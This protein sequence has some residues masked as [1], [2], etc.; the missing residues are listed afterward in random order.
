LRWIGPNYLLEQA[1]D[2]TGPWTPV[3]ESSMPAT[4]DLNAP[5]KF[6]RLRR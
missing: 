6:Y 1:D 4:I 5:K 3:V 2:V